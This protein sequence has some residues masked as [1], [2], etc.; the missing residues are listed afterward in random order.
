MAESSG[1]KVGILFRLN[2]EKREKML[3]VTRFFEFLIKNPRVHTDHVGRHGLRDRHPRQYLCPL[4]QHHQERHRPHRQAIRHRLYRDMELLQRRHTP[5]R[6]V[7]HMP[8]TKRGPRRSRHHRQNHISR[9]KNI[10]SL[11]A[12][13]RVIC[14][15]STPN[16]FYQLS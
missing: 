16:T 4:H 8:G 3:F 6:Q 10:I 12:P 11:L 5:L 9:V 13:E 15:L 1:A 2:K 7:R 14:E